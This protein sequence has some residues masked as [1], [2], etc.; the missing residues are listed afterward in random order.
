VCV[1]VCCR[2]AVA[3]RFLGDIEMADKIRRRCIEMCQEFHMT[4]L[5]LSDRFLAELERHNYVTPTSYLEMINTFKTLLAKKREQVT[6]VT[7]F[8]VQTTTAITS[9]ATR[10]YIDYTQSLVRVP[11]CSYV[12]F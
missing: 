1:C 11:C 9:L 5:K 10:S 2:Q 4:T 6:K 12:G 7:R 3:T 8:S